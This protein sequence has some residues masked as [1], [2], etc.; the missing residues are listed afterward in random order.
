MASLFRSGSVLSIESEIIRAISLQ[1]T[2]FLIRK[3]AIFRASRLVERS[4]RM[5]ISLSFASSVV[6][7][8]RSTR[9]TLF[10][11]FLVGF[12]ANTL[13]REFA[14]SSTW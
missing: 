14:S 6:S 10:G 2:V 13:Q 4:R 3:S 1:G 7:A 11:F 5:G 8:S 12:S 9:R